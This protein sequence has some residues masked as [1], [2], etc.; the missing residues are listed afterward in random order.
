M[1]LVIGSGPAGVSVAMARLARGHDVIMIDGGKKLTA[2][3]HSRKSD[4]AGSSPA[5]W[6]AA[7]IDSWQS[8]QFDNPEG[9]AL[10]YG[11]DHAQNRAEDVFEK[12]QWFAG[13]S[14]FAV[15]GLS[16]VWG[17]AVL[18]N[19]Q[20]DMTDWPVSAAQLA[21]HYKAVNQFMPISGQSDGLERIFPDFDLTGH[22]PLQPG[23][24]GK[25][26]LAKL[27]ATSDKLR[28]KGVHSGQARLAVRSSCQLCGMCLHG[29]PWDQIYSATQTLVKLQEFE[30][31]SYKSGQVATRFEQDSSGGRLKLDDGSELKF[32]RMF[33]A[34]GV[35]ETARLVLASTS[36]ASAELTLRDSR[37]FFLP[38]L[39]AW[40]PESDPSIGSHHTLAEA[41]V[42]IDDREVSPYL[43]HTQ[44]Y[45]WNEFYARE[46]I[47]N[48]GA[49]LPPLAPFFRTLS[50]RLMVA[51]T[52]IH[53]DHCDTVSLK[54]NHASRRLVTRL[55]QAPGMSDVIKGAER[56]LS[57]T[58]RRVGLYA[59][60][61]ASRV[62]DAG[63][64]FHSGGTLPMSH[65]PRSLETD[66]LGRLS[67][68]PNIHVVDASVLPSIPATT[69]TF[70]VMANA[71]R[72][73]SLA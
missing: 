37:H 42:E 23:V 53:S 30:R 67:G 10:R 22:S 4:M 13:R 48:Y 65:K 71:H 66:E 64:S 6:S 27:N 15:G 32:D 5:D 1:D 73:G 8:P 26:L 17:A 29:C 11:S 9:T 19:R 45:G 60:Q 41:F 56:K 61:F 24:Q 72:I 51:Q 39:H 69:I 14:S 44:I 36:E 25:N 3:L 62:G 38:M 40:R 43:T 63:S 7:Q 52:F 47:Q 12:A 58:M 50:R 57:T 34:A 46:M 33:I 28:S 21:P 59:L 2:E 16:N 55:N 49:K 20:A 68:H 18:P 35:Y 70:S 31:F 54:L